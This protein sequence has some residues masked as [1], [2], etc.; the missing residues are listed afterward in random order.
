MLTLE[1]SYVIPSRIKRNDGVETGGGQDMDPHFLPDDRIVFSSSRQTAEQARQLDEGRAQ[2]F[3]RQTEGDDD[4][5]ALV[6]HIYDPQQRDAEFKQISFNRDHDLD[7]VVLTSGEIIFSRWDSDNNHI[8]LYRITPSGLNLSPL[9][10]FDSQNSGTEGSAVEYTQ[11]RE[12]DDGRIISLI[13]PFES[14]TLGGALA[15]LDIENYAGAG[16]TLTGAAAA[17]AGEGQEPLTE[18]EIRTDGL[19][20]SGGQFGSV[21]PLRDGTGRLL[22]TWTDCRLVEVPNDVAVED[23]PVVEDPPPEEAVEEERIIPCTLGDENDEPADP[24]YGAW[25][26]DVEGDTQRPVVL[27]EDGFWISEIVAAEPR[28]FPSVL[29]VPDNFDPALAIEGKGQLI[30]DSV[31]DF[32]GEDRSPAGIAAHRRPA[33]PEF[34][35]RPAR[36]LRLFMP[37]PLPN[38]DIFE[39]PRYAFGVSTAFGFREVVGYVPIEPDGSVSVTVPA[40]RVIGFSILDADARRIVARHDYWL[41]VGA[42]EVLRCTGCHDR[43]ND[44]PHGRTDTQPASANPGATDVGGMVGFPNTDIDNLFATETGATMADTWDFHRPADNPVVAER[45]LALA[46]NYVDEWTAPTLTPEAP[47]EGRDYPLDW[48][49]VPPE[50]PLVATKLDPN[51]P[52][53]IVINYV[54]HI[55]PIWERTRA[56]VADVDGNLHTNCV[57]CHTS[58]DNT[59]VPEGQLDLTTLPSDV[60]PDHYRSY[61]ELLSGDNEQWIDAAGNVA[62]RLRLCEEIVEQVDADGNIIQVVL[63]FTENLAIG[64][65]ARVGSANGS[66]RFF[67]CFEG[68]SCGLPPAPALPA[69]CTEDGTPIPRTQN[70]INH[71]GMLSPAELRLLSEWL[72]IGGQYYNNPFDGRLVD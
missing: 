46:P 37:V 6:L 5:P 24:L 49:G 27:A 25:V 54:D 3:A 19:L 7:P 43:R 23:P 67:D 31:Y 55:Q 22:V 16:Q 61:R 58:L 10:G 32:D 2:L 57:S 38:E 63:T 48:E 21:Y 35:Q 18:T 51:A 36:F 17:D 39:V 4:Q 71:N 66:G 44:V 28:D 33:T 50:Y 68:G 40:D 8:S 72:D 47:L 70:T 53:R 12:L 29:P 59:V 65:P 15:I 20:S 30:I 42:G 60:D 14:P 64:S 56:E 52:D 1:P 11:P 41:Q 26:Y 45:A 13:R 9:F 69:N 34:A 62:D